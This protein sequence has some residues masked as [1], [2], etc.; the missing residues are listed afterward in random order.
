MENDKV[1]EKE[2][3]KNCQ[4][5]VVIPPIIL[6]LFVL[7]ALLYQMVT[8]K[9]STLPTISNSRDQKPNIPLLSNLHCRQHAP[10]SS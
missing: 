3:E 7:K 2:K 5:R 10:T 4:N 9:P 6:N 8:T 1:K